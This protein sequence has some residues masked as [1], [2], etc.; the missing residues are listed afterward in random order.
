[1]FTTYIAAAF[2][3]A[4]TPGLIGVT[5]A[6]TTLRF[7]EGVRRRCGGNLRVD[8]EHV[9]AGRGADHVNN[10]VVWGGDRAVRAVFARVPEAGAGGEAEDNAQPRQVVAVAGGANQ[11]EALGNDVAR[12]AWGDAEV[13]LGND[14]ALDAA[15]AG[16]GEVRH[17]GLAHVQPQDQ[18]D[19]AGR[20]ALLIDED[21][22][23]YWRVQT[24]RDVRTF[25]CL[26]A[27]LILTNEGRP[28]TKEEHARL[29]A[30][31]MRLAK[32]KGVLDVQVVKNSINAAILAL[33]DNTAT[34][35]ATEQAAVEQRKLS[36]FANGLPLVNHTPWV[37]MSTA[38][39]CDPLNWVYWFEQK[40][41]EINARPSPFPGK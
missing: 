3:G 21:D 10:S 31:A 20:G 26:V 5:A 8:Q 33:R 28:L 1:M 40:W 11:A 37:V 18:D 16:Q 27:R 4:A 32:A 14:Q 39:R 23:G 17:D 24:V 7:L 34:I 25:P 38:Q 6:A 19:E 13:G 41:A 9:D 36:D 12:D 30:E 29:T 2:V 35:A 15:Q 22:A